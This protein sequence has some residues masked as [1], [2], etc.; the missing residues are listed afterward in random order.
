VVD[1]RLKFITLQISGKKQTIRVEGLKPHA[2]SPPV[3]STAERTTGDYY[4]FGPNPYGEDWGW[5]D[6]E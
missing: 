6:C 4:F 5:G 3:Y 1:H 2:G